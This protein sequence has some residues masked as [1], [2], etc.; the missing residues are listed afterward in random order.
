MPV[1]TQLIN[2]YTI[3]YESSFDMAFQQMQSKLRDA[4]TIV[5][6]SGE[7][8]RLNNFGLKTATEITE[9]GGDTV[10]TDT[11]ITLI[12]AWPT[13][14]EAVDSVD[15]FDPVHLGDVVLPNSDF[16][17]NQ[18]YAINRFM[19]DKI[20][21]AMNGTRY[22]GKNATTTDTL[23]SSQQVAVDFEDGS[24]NTG[25]T[26][27]KIAHAQYILDSNEAD[28]NDRFL[29]V[30]AKQMEDLV[31]DVFANH[32]NDLQSIKMVPGTR[33]IDEILGF[34][35]LRAQRFLLDSSTDIRS[36]IAWQKRAMAFGIWNE[37]NVH[38]DVL[39]TK[40]HQTQIRTTV[41]VGAVRRYNE[42]L[43]EILCDESP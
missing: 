13:A 6:A 37:R 20:V 22:L 2:A 32:S 15:E 16:V 41:N 19:D 29:G 35:I 12:N 11:D 34:R 26:F 9:R 33:W 39:P 14:C 23:P 4:V 10:A 42:G 27:N 21:A 38:I 24:T 8:I 5:P 30:T 17:M 3:Q 1:N 31:L 43:V 40:R 28:E 36:V 7:R 25:L 18:A